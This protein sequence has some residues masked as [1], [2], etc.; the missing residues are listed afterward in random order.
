[1]G[2]GELRLESTDFAIEALPNLHEVL[3]ELRA[4]EPVS[5]ILFAGKPI[6]LVNDYETV[7]R[8]IGSDDVLSAPDAYEHIVK[9]AMGNVLPTM[10]GEQHRLNRAVVSRVFFPG[11]MREYAESMFAE[12][13][14]KLADGL[15]GHSRVDLVASF[16]RSYTFNNIARL[17]GLPA[18]DVTRLQ[19]WADRIMRSYVD[20]PDARAAGQEMGKYLLPMVKSRRAQPRDDVLSLL[21]HAEVDDEGL[22]DDEILGFCRNLFPAA[23]DTSTNSLGSLLVVALQ[24]REMWR[25]LPQDRKLRED[26]VYELLRWEPPLVMIPRRA[27]H[28]MELGGQHLSAGDDVRLCITG[29]HDDPKQFPEPRAFKL[30][31]GVTHLAFGHGEHFCLGTQMAKRVVEKGI[32]VLCR[33]FPEM[34]LCPDEKAEILGGV[35]RGPR[36][37]QV[38][39]LGL[40]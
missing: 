10:T 36:T 7:S 19:D 15:A 8:H 25:A 11:R 39:P 40:S 31:R 33:R 37:L 32:E 28:D 5:R 6:W 23:I 16:T 24:D 1:M 17:L 3:A 22:S 30:D 27:V 38:A 20:V 2:N 35:L 34:V 12:E 18:R 26:A 4:V 14:E 9:P 21:A 13:A 29:A